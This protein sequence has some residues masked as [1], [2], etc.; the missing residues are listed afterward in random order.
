MNTPNEI[1]FE[2]NGVNITNPT[3][4]ECGRMGCSPKYY[5]FEIE[6][7]GGGCT[8]WVKY[9]PDGT[10]LMLTD[11]V[12]AN[13]RDGQIADYGRYDVEGNELQLTTITVGRF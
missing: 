8:A 13:L 1:T 12:S 9:L 11:E 5:G 3:A 7:T 4:S 10:Y 2:H 6:Q